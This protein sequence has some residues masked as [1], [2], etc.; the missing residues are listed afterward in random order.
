[1]N[2]NSQ[3]KKSFLNK[4]FSTAFVSFNLKTLNTYLN[5]YSSNYSNYGIVKSLLNLLHEDNDISNKVIKILKLKVTF[6]KN[7]L[8]RNKI[9]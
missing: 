2:N 4:K 6:N 1:M 7:L 5:N 3:F 9:Q 8:L